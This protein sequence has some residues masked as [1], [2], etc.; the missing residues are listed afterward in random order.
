MRQGSICD[1]IIA[2]LF[3]K[4]YQRPMPNSKSRSIET[5]ASHQEEKHSEIESDVEFDLSDLLASGEQILKDEARHAQL[6][7][8]TKA[9]VD[10]MIRRQH[11][12]ITTVMDAEKLMDQELKRIE[13]ENPFMN[14][15]VTEVD[16][17]RLL[18][19][20]VIN[21]KL[22]EDLKKVFKMLNDLAKIE[23]PSSVAL[24]HYERVVL[25][26]NTQTK[27]IE[28]VIEGKQEEIRARREL[29]KE[30]VIQSLK[31]KSDRMEAIVAEVM[32]N[33]RVI[34]QL[35]T[36]ME[37]VSVREEEKNK[38]EAEEILKEAGTTIQ[39]L[40][41]RHR[42]ALDRLRV[43]TKDPDLA[44]N[45]AVEHL[46]KSDDPK[47]TE[48]VL[49]ETQRALKAA[50]LEKE[51]AEQIKSPS[52]VVPWE[53][54][55]SVHYGESITFL[56]SKIVEDTLRHAGDAG[57][58]KAQKLLELRSQL[59]LENEVLRKL[60]GPKWSFNPKTKE[61]F[62]GPFWNLF[63]ERKHAGARKAEAEART[64]KEKE[65]RDVRLKAEKAAADKKLADF[66]ESAKDVLA[67]GGFVV[68]APVYQQGA[69]GSH[70]VGKEPIVVR[71]EETQDKKMMR[72]WKVAE[73]HGKTDGVKVG[74]VYT[75]DLL[76]A[77]YF[78]R[79][80]A[81]KE[82]LMDGPNF[83]KR[84]DQVE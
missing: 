29:L 75:R 4:I 46:Q 35:Q 55:T 64:K 81:K 79:E 32:A 47:K 84:K 49:V 78:L 28:K 54:K 82:F 59:M 8:M 22:A 15:S 24:A 65:A 43:I 51:G 21:K 41:A 5:G 45:L 33:P 48:K 30:S 20:G 56:K 3:D 23:N 12:A 17:D 53:N 57:D 39:S 10:A 11:E 72:T 58:A 36:E 34:D 19:E 42:N 16:L 2:K 6:A 62:P 40:S 13:E 25:T 61:K 66:M 67:R 18:S 9:E 69:S 31:E 77:P 80:A 83:V 70:L 1:S 26:L 74:M 76:N 68:E 50:V 63:E 73:V 37:E 71:L 7:A 52:E 14:G 38:K 27:Q 60:F 44:Y